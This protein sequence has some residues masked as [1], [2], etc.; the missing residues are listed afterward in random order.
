MK[1]IDYIESTGEQYIDTG[2]S[3][4]D[5]SLKIE[6]EYMPTEGYTSE[7]AVFG[8]TWY[9]AG[10]FLMVAGEKWGFHS[11]YSVI[12]PE[13]CDT[14]Q[15]TKIIATYQSLFIN[16]VEYVLSPTST[17]S[18]D[19]ILLFSANSSYADSRRG[20][21][22]IK[23]C[24]IWLGE[25][26][27]RDFIP[28]LDDN[29]IACLYD[30]ISATY[31]YNKGTGTFKDNVYIDVD[32]WTANELYIMEEAGAFTTINGR[33]YTKVNP[34]KALVA[35]FYDT[36][37]YTAPLLISTDPD[38]VT[39]NTYGATWTYASTLNYLGLTWYVSST[40][41]SMAGNITPTGFAQKIGAYSLSEAPM[42]LI[43]IAEVKLIIKYLIESN[44]IYYNIVDGVLNQLDITE[45]NAEAFATYG[46]LG[47]SD[48]SLLSGLSKFSIYG[49]LESEDLTPSFSTKLIATPFTQTIISNA[50]DL[51]DNSI[52]GINSVVFTGEGEL[53]MSVSF[54]DK[55]SWK[56]WDV[57]N[58]TWT[59]AADEYSGMNKETV[60]AITKEQWDLLY[61]GADKF[62]IKVVL[63]DATQTI[64]QIK[65]QFVN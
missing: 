12:R 60:E 49:W 10:F 3:A 16:G 54:D 26:L 35:T 45:L 53:I 19:N 43:K 63:Q 15:F 62:Y 48:S 52:T 57:T 34:G 47:I 59:D 30:N 28:V 9:E 42:A 25:E 61:I 56:I 29:N 32:K 5:T 50:I 20:R 36:N 41:Y 6:I 44:N 4:A 14:T 21:G 65:V 22:K 58:E 55:A 23:Y 31:F 38:A 1:I 2:I 18:V 17:N 46:T 37:G 33:V 27:V 40:Q 24:K 51:T 64:E 8:S 7:Y 13:A 11:G 39:Y